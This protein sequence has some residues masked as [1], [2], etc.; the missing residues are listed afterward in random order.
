MLHSLQELAYLNTKKLGF[1][2][3]IERRITECHKKIIP[4]FKKARTTPSGR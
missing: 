4:P 3:G 1:E 2:N